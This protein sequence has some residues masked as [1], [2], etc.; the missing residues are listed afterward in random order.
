MT[1]PRNIAQRFG[2]VSTL[3]GGGFPVRRPFP[4]A[5][6]AF[7]DPFMLLDHMGPKDWPPGEAL[8]APPHPHRGF[9]TVTYLLQ[10]KFEHK[11]S[12]GH[13]GKLGPGDVQWMNA[14]SGAVHSELPEAEFKRQ[15]GVLEGIQ[16]WVNLPA[17]A[18][19]SEPSYQEFPK[20]QL[21]ELTWPHAWARLIAGSLEGQQ[22]PIQTT[23]PI[24]Y[25]HVKLEAG[26][27][28]SLP[29][30]AELTGYLYILH[31]QG[32]FG[33]ELWNGEAGDW[34]VMGPGDEVALTA[35]EPCELLMLGAVPLN[36]PVARYG[37]FVMNSKSEIMQ[38]IE[39]YESGKMGR[40]EP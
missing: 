6:L 2:S 20:E 28:L 7:A 29:L 4:T 22:S 23:T 9:Q 26:A 3:E 34:L 11:D 8:G 19:M 27:D 36:E 40:I 32:R 12:A 13:S 5:D 35:E 31:G 14:G 37:P 16:L 30:D 10:G 17:S 24:F 33:A 38:A 25:A 18:K 21:P 39:D 1:T 15:G